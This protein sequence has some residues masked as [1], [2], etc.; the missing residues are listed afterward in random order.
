MT[1]VTDAA[2]WRIRLTLLPGSA[3]GPNGEIE[4]R[5]ETIQR[6]AYR[7]DVDVT[8][9]GLRPGGEFLERHGRAAHTV[10]NEPN[11]VRVVSWS[12]HLSVGTASG[13]RTR[14]DHRRPARDLPSDWHAMRHNV[15]RWVCRPDRRAHD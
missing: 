7:I 5:G 1:I 4:R 3:A 14:V 11:E 12:R 2:D 9:R 13:P 8:I 15:V 10:P 6:D